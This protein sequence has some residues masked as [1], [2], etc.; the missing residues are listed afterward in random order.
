MK[1]SGFRGMTIK[2]NRTSIKQMMITSVL[3]VISLF[4]LVS[5][6]TS[7]GQGRGFSSEYI[8][9]WSAG[10]AGEQL[11]QVMG[12]ENT[13]FTE[14]LPEG[15]RQMQLAPLAFHMVTSLNPEDPRSFLG[16]ELPGFAFFDSQ[17]YIAGVGTDYTTLSHESSPPIDVQLAERDAKQE[18]LEKVIQLEK[19]A[20]EAK[21]QQAQSEQNTGEKKVV[22]IINT[23]DTESFLPELNSD[24]AFNKKVNITQTSEKLKQELE[25]RGIGATREERSV[26]ERV[27]E[28]G[29]EYTQSY[30]AAREFLTEAMESSPDFELYFDLHRDS[31][32]RSKTT[33]TINGEEYA[34][35]FFVVGGNNPNSQ[36][37]TKMAEDLNAL[38]EEKYP[39]LSRGVLTKE[40]SKTNGVFNQDLA[41]QSML[42]EIGGVDNTLEETYRSSEALADVIAEYYWTIQEGEGS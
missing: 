19:E 36:Y 8:H 10:L 27:H 33:V 14:P 4:I 16:R 35:T 23:H 26:Q 22:Y 2:V 6:L 15:S 31:S 9:T 30:D 28:K 20:E 1:P 40:G 12:M 17:I 21:R 34:R 5:V 38:L 39:G 18:S 7:F 13:H 11:L 25:K 29:W 37:N 32:N 24:E 41:P 42:I 3:G